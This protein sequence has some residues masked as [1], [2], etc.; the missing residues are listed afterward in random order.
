MEERQTKIREGAGLEESRLNVE[1]I[2]WMKKYSTPMLLVVVVIAGGYFLWNWYEKAHEKGI[3][4]AF[5]QLDAAAKSANPT[6]LTRVADEQNRLVV[7]HQARLTAADIHLNAGRN[8]V[9]IGTTLVTDPSKTPGSLP[10]GTEPLT[11]EQRSDE[12]GKAQALYQQVFDGTKDSPDLVLQTVAALNGLAACAEMRKQPDAAKGYYQ[13]VIERA[14]AAKYPDLGKIA[15]HMIDTLDAIQNPPKLY[16]ESKLPKA[17]AD[18][19]P[20]TSPLS[21]IKMMGP[22]GKEIPTGPGAITPKPAPGPGDSGPAPEPGTQTP[23][24]TA[25][26]GTPA[27]TPA[28]PAPAPTPAAPAPATPANPAPPGGANAPK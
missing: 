10:E 9:P 1:F 4:E 18:L 11:E 14:N 17:A 16:A 2:D 5:S 23:P 25:P 7:P 28:S 15:Q 24:A 12:L 13:Q 8:G 20:F 19:Q 3:D 26:G 21:N 22:D 6:S 27:P